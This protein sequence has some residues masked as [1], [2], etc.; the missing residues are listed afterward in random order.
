MA[1]TTLQNCQ[2]IILLLEFVIIA[3]VTTFQTVR[4]I[5]KKIDLNARPKKEEEVPAESAAEK[6]KEEE[7]T[8]QQFDVAAVKSTILADTDTCTERLMKKICEFN[9]LF[10]PLLLALPLNFILGRSK[11]FSISMFFLSIV[12]CFLFNVFKVHRACV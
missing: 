5:K 2:R 9:V 12:C 11:A 7:V 3:L 4:L 8:R 1:S 10:N 6:Y